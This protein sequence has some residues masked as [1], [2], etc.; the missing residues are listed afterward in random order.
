MVA[1]QGGLSNCSRVE[2]N[3]GAGD[4]AV[5]ALRWGPGYRIYLAKG[6]ESLIVLF[7]GGTKGRQHAELCF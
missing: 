3:Y 7:G 5:P 1:N 4:F 2:V 6:G